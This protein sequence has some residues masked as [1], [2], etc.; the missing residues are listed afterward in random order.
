MC[1]FATLLVLAAVATSGCA[2]RAGS[3]AHVPRPFPAPGPPSTTPAS[4]SA[5]VPD[6]AVVP[7]TLDGYAVAGTALSLRG[8]RYVAG[9]S[10][11]SGFDCSGLVWYVYAQ[12]GV[13][14]PRTVSDQF[15]TGEPVNADEIETGDLVFFNT[16]GRGATHVGIAIGGE[17]F[18]HAPNSNGEV[19]VDRLGGAYWRTRFVGA[20]RL[21]PRLSPHGAQN[22]PRG[23]RL[24]PRDAVPCASAG[25]RSCQ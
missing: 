7:G 14:L 12:H 10:D 11:P 18:V 20:R 24:T 5:A 22:A 3:G 15:L 19:R 1:R 13:A 9:G 21:S 23:P 25:A 17:E 4:E 6:A 2:A 8:V 16:K